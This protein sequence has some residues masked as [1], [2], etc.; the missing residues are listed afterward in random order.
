MT[1]EHMTPRL[2]VATAAGR[3]YLREA[4]AVDV[5]NHDQLAASHGHLTTALRHLLV[6]L[7]EGE[8]GR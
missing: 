5:H 6:A 8:V 3:R 1:G 2:A 4:D 7:G